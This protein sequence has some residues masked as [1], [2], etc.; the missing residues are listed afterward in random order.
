MISQ[1]E[2]MKFVL[3]QQPAFQS[4]WQSF[5]DDWGAEEP[6]LCNN[7]AEFSEYVINLANEK[8]TQ[9]FTEIFN[10]VE[11]LLVDGDKTVKDA[12]ATCF[13][14]NLLNAASNGIIDPQSFVPFLSQESRTYC[15]AWD[16]FT[17]V[18]TPG[19]W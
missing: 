14:E 1:Q 18:H 19:L 15:K 4:R 10:L 5:L 9:N 3:K 16:E 17:G 11:Q 8:S 12:I 13:L 6:G 7:I 2:C